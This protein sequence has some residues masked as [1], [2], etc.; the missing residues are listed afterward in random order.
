MEIA[1]QASKVIEKYRQLDTVEL[2]NW[3]LGSNGTH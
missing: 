2:H 1:I 3:W